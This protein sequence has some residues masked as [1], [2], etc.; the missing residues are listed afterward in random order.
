MINLPEDKYS[1]EY[2][3][4]PFSKNRTKKENTT[5]IREIFEDLKKESPQLIIIEAP[6]GF[7]KTSTS[8]EIPC[9]CG[10]QY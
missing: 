8:Y 2:I 10:V 1:Y 7:G 6:A 3:D 4:S 9:C 5:I